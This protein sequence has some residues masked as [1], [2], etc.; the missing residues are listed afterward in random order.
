MGRSEAARAEKLCKRVST[1]RATGDGHQL[2]ATAGLLRTRDDSGWS[3]AV[4]TLC[5]VVV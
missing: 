3:S 2:K 4:Q 1:H 5:V